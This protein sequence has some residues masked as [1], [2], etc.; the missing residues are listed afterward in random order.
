MPTDRV[1]LMFARVELPDLGR[2]TGTEA[3][4]KCGDYCDYCGDCLLCSG[5]MPCYGGRGELEDGHSWVVYVGQ[6]RHAE[7]LAKAVGEEEADVAG[8]G[9]E[10]PDAD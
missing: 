8:D 7:L 2:Y 4:V 9:A 1:P 6:P 3:T 10:G 5:D